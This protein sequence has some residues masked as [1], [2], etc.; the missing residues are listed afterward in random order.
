M[1]SW[2]EVTVTT[3]GH[4]PRRWPALLASALLLAACASPSPTPS[5]PPTAAHGTPT[6][7]PTLTPAPTTSPSP[8][9]SSTPT[10]AAWTELAT[11]R[12]E[13]VRVLVAGGPGLIA[14]GCRVST[15]VSY[16]CAKALI[17]TSSDGS[18]WTEAT[19]G[20][21]AGGNIASIQKVGDTYVA[22][23]TRYLG[24]MDLRGGVWT[25]RDGTRWALVAMFPG[26]V[27]NAVVE[28]DGRLL[29]VGTGYP[30]AGEPWG[31]TVWELD[32]VGHWEDGR[33]VQ[34]PQGY[35]IRSVIPT[36]GGY[37]AFGM[38]NPMGINA[39]VATSTDGLRWRVMPE[40]ASL[41]GSTLLS[42][43]ER[44]RGFLA[45]GHV[46]GSG[47]F[48]PA[49][50]HS[51]DAL[52]WERIEDPGG[53]IPGQPVRAAVGDGRLLL[54]GYV[55]DGEANRTTSWESLDGV[56][57]TTLAAGSDLPDLAGAEVSD[58]VAV[59]GRRLVVASLGA[60][61][62][63]RSVI[64]AQPGAPVLATPAPTTPASAVPAKSST[65]TPKPVAGWPTVGRAGVTMTGT[66]EDWDPGGR[67]R[68]S[69]SLTG[70]APGEAAS[71]EAAGEYDIGWIC[72]TQPEPCGPI[73]CGP[74][75]WDTT[76]GSAKAAA[77]AEA[78]TD[79]TVSVRVV[80]V[81][82]PPA[83]ACPADSSPPWVAKDERWEQV[84]LTD[85]AHGLLLTP[86]TIGRG[87]TY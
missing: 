34:T 11:F 7:A 38:N 27:A 86:D 43:V 68:L 81:A 84:S 18:T 3:W 62:A 47:A 73:G 52:N 30:Y 37:L 54:R 51:A 9:L 31:F 79:G 66:V 44:D 76:Q 48:T 20:D 72:G 13:M 28:R 14:A 5:P 87:F 63:V 6:G 83:A 22:L 58:P 67:L 10:P 57:W 70:L 50:W 46:F 56:H 1:S 75:G 16:E 78:G 41:S 65:P 24:G 39:V 69:I 85:S 17:R 42:V 59:A 74:V 32:G 40:Q 26:Q 36:S 21:A 35:F 64:Y 49:V 29:G 53:P 23:G 45:V 61:D 60:T 77:Q 12:G 4:Q 71:L 55:V 2:K 25:S 15:K 80:L 8:S 19:V 33:V 82:A